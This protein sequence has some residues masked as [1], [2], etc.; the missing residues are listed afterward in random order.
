MVAIGVTRHRLLTDSDKIADG[1]GRA[2]RMIEDTFPGQSLAAI[3][4]LTEG[5]DRSV[6]RQVLARP[7]AR[8]VVPMPMP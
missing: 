8:L 7:A 2:L 3:S 4:P 5:A 6:A 1:I